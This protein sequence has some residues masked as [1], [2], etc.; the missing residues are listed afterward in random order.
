MK[1]CYKC[2]ETKDESCFGSNKAKKG[3]LHDVCK[4]CA[5]NHI[6][7]QREKNGDS[8]KRKYWADAEYRESVKTKVRD[9]ARKN[10]EWKH[11]TRLRKYGLTE[12]KYATMQ[13]EQQGLCAICR[14]KM[15]KVCIDHDHRTGCVRGLLCVNCNSGIGYLQDSA[16]VL[17][18]AYEY[19]THYGGYGQESECV[20]YGMHEG[21]RSKQSTKEKAHEPF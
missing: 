20:P 3:G 8:R 2:K 6:R 4:P 9:A 7:D 10:P 15:E 16:T 18:R 5:V 11:R 12:E 19:I 14:N 13:D 17:F 21:V 1:Y